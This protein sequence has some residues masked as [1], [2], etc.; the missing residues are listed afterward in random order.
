MST[1]NGGDSILH[2][3]GTTSIAD[4]VGQASPSSSAG[5]VGPFPAQGLGCSAYQ[6]RPVPRDHT[7]QETSNEESRD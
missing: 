3:D 2:A 1:L 6:P 7:E 4:N 5:F